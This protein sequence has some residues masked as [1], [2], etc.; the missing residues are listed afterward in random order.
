MAGAGVV[1]VFVSHHHS[2]EEDRFTARL[3]AD[4][5]AAGADIWVD[6]Q[7]ITSNNFVQKISEGL[8]GRQWLVLVMTP[9][10]VASPWVRNEV[11]A[12]LSEL[13][14]G[15]MLGVIPILMTPTPEQD[16]PILWRSLHRY[17]A[18]HTYEPARDG[19]LRALGL[20]IPQHLSTYIAT[21]STSTVS[22]REEA[23]RRRERRNNLLAKKQQLEQKLAEAEGRPQRWHYDSEREQWKNDLAEINNLLLEDDGRWHPKE[24][25]S[26]HR[27]G[28]MDD[29]VEVWQ[30]P[31]CGKSTISEQSPSQYRT[32]GCERY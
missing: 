20:P 5:K 25:I 6:D 11:S 7:N 2:S 27:G 3:V 12:A 13:A 14:A 29:Y 32:D 4:L 24:P 19:L 1:R 23:I 18:T 28:A 26:V 10:S 8:E 15:R 22:P 17:D 31:C 21:S 30:F 9:Q 16:I